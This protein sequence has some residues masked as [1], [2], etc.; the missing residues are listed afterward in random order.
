MCAVPSKLD[1]GEKMSFPCLVLSSPD[2]AFSQADSAS[3]KVKF[4]L[5]K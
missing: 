2:T 3:K 1:N 4:L 5:F